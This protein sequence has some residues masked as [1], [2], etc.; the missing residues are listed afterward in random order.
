[1]PAVYPE[2]SGANILTTRQTQPLCNIRFIYCSKTRIKNTPASGLYPA[3]SIS[4][5]GQKGYP[6]RLAADRHYRLYLISTATSNGTSNSKQGCT[7]LKKRL[8]PHMQRY[9]ITGVIT[10]IPIWITWLVF[11]F[12]FT[13]L[14]S[15]G[16]PWV[17]AIADGVGYILPDAGGWLLEPWFQQTLAVVITLA[18]LYLLG[19]FA[20]RVIGVKALALMDIIINKIPLLQTIYGSTKKL[21][22]VLQQKPDKLQRVVLI[23]FPSP[24]M[25]TVGFVTRI[26]KDEYTGQELA[27]VYVPTTPNP[28]SGYLEIVPVEKLISTDWTMEEAMTFIISGGAIA[29]EKISYFKSS[30]KSAPTTPPAA[31]ETT[32]LQPE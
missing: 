16:L 20:S 5:Q 26:L 10:V 2:I 7:Q 23:E 31:A 19:W 15:A 18:A 22:T 4:S 24:H 8:I 29:P 14:S 11:N 32:P 6:F 21:L 17:R 25:K 3:G 12:I 9:L 30:E 28:T 1:M 13:Q 27:A